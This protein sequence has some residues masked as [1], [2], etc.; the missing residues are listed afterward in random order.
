M[1]GDAPLVSVIT[2]TYNWSSVLHYALLS[3]QA[4]TFANFELL[5]I[6]D[7]CTDDSA[8]VVAAFR[9]PRFRWENLPVNH[10]HQSVANN[11][12]LAQA[13]GK[14]IAYLGHDDLW[15][16]NHLELLVEK[17]D[18]SNADVAFSLGIL[19]GAPDCGGRL[20][21]PV[22][23]GGEFQRGAHV[24]P[25]VLIHR[26]SLLGDGAEWP[27]YRSTAGSPEAAL[28]SRFYDQGAKFAALREVTVFKFPS[29]WRLDSYVE[30]SCEEQAAFFTRMQ[31][32]PDFLHRELIEL[33]VADQLLTPHT[34]TVAPAAEPE[35]RPGAL[36]E[37]CR[38]NRGLTS[39]PPMEGPPRYLPSPAL[40]QLAARLSDEE[41]R[42]RELSRFA[43]FEIF[44]ARQGLYGGQ[45]FTRTLVPM[46]KWTRLRI[47]LEHLSEGAP[48]RIDPCDR[49]ALIEI[50]WV[51]LSRKGLVE[52]SAQSRALANLTLGGD[53]VA[54]NWGL[55][56]TLRSLGADPMIFLP[57][58]VTAGPP[59]IF[60]AR[61]RINPPG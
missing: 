6:G 44:Y 43:L 25:S 34:R 2:A 56:F 60:E 38:R 42:R 28:L 48:L 40:S 27:D 53:A 52:W 4:Q 3:A 47:P 45:A 39:E 51:R 16:P 61:I 7:G 35:P 12:G 17:L 22:F 8:E 36:V 58:E 37:D 19:V 26:R 10:G 18:E 30:R 9:D 5:V 46:R 33:A 21:A 1:H 20:L 31:H 29:S 23:P 59:Q 41:I 32:E 15:M 55:T 24:P 11:R 50:A 14:W 57:A 54:I 49:P 13:R